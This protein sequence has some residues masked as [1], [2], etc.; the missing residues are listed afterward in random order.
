[1]LRWEV[2]DPADLDDAIN[3]LSRQGH[4]LYFI[5]DE[6]EVAG[7][8]SR[9]PHTRTGALLDRRVRAATKEFVER[10]GFVVYDLTPPGPA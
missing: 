1:M 9:F 8:K 4:A 3:H 10:Y 2:V 7:F 5:G 6:F